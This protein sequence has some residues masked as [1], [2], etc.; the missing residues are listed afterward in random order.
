MYSFLEWQGQISTTATLTESLITFY[1]SYSFLL[2]EPNCLHSSFS[3]GL[4]GY[5]YTFSAGEGCIPC[6]N[7]QLWDESKRYS[8]RE[9]H[10]PAAQICLK[11]QKLNQICLLPSFLASF[12]LGGPFSIYPYAAAN[13]L[14][15]KQLYLVTPLLLFEG[16]QEL[17][18]A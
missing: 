4:Y 7:T 10:Y 5:F 18:T 3:E 14:F 6:S 2:F 16:L 11:I 17:L 15:Q 1:S 8:N 9:N 13:V 12:I